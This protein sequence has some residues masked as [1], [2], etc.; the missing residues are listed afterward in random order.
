MVQVE[1]DRSPEFQLLKS[2]FRFR[3]VNAALD[4]DFD[5]AGQRAMHLLTG[6]NPSW[7]YHVVQSPSGQLLAVIPNLKLLDLLKVMR[8]LEAAFALDATQ[9]SNW[10]LAQVEAAKAADP[11]ALKHSASAGDFTL[12]RDLGFWLQPLVQSFDSQMGAFGDR[13][14]MARPAAYMNLLHLDRLGW[15]AAVSESFVGGPRLGELALSQIL[16]SKLFDCLGGG[17]FR[18][19]D[20]DLDQGTPQTE[21]LLSHNVQMLW[22][23]VKAYEASGSEFIRRGA[24]ETLEF[25]LRDLLNLKSG[26]FHAYLSA[27]ASFY[28]LTKV[29]LIEA[30]APGQ[31]FVAAHFFGLETETGLPRIASTVPN[32]STAAM[33]SQDETAKALEQARSDL[34]RQRAKRAERPK[35]GPLALDSDQ[36]WAQHFVQRAADVLGLSHMLPASLRQ[37]ATP[38]SPRVLQE[39]VTQVGPFWARHSVL[40]DQCTPDL[41]VFCDDFLTQSPAESLALLNRLKTSGLASLGLL[42]AV[43]AKMGQKLA[44][45][46]AD[47]WVHEPADRSP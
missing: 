1:Q 28:S 17:F 20:F 46:S 10:A 14:K 21:K 40:D 4:A 8:E 44:K 26:Q 16:R 30:L 38:R 37:S 27:E 13:I 3:S 32:A 29:D 7:P 33:L 24:V 35:V 25:L 5:V 19:W 6:Q 23:L 36:Q 18:A 45:E 47:Q 12:P 43:L 11:W 41:G 34:A 39:C 31:R 2:R 9:F 15:S 22:V 42:N